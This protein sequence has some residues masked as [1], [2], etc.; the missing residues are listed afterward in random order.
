MPLGSALVDGDVPGGEVRC[1][2]LTEDDAHALDRLVDTLDTGL[3]HFRDER[4]QLVWPAALDEGDLNDGHRHSP[5]LRKTEPR[6]VKC[7]ATDAP[8]GENTASVM[9][10]VST[11]QPGSIE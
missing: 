7:S 1:G 9:P 4:A 5:P 2:D 3:G 8:G 10:P 11:I 6:L